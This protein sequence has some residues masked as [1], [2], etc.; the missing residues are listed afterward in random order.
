MVRT[1]FHNVSREQAAKIARMIIDGLADAK[2]Y[3]TFKL[4]F[5]T[6]GDESSVEIVKEASNGKTE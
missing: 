5:D 6:D 3:E 4:S 2:N 1:I